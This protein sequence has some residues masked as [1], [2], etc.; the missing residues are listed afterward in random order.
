MISIDASF[1]AGTIIDSAAKI[2]R[3]DQ[4]VGRWYQYSK[5]KWQIVEDQEIIDWIRNSCADYADEIILR[6][7][8]EEFNKDSLI[9]LASAMFAEEVESLLRN[10]EYCGVVSGRPKW[11]DKDNP[12]LLPTKVV[13]AAGRATD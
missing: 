6:K 10:T 2:F 7:R 5:G 12:L 9:N 1:Y 3:Y 4:S 13:K 11:S 8:I